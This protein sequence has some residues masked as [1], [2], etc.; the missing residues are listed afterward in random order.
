MRMFR[1]AITVLML[2]AP[3]HALAQDQ[4]TLAD[5]RQELTILYVEMQKLKRE[6]STTGGAT[7]NLAAA[8]VLDRVSAI[9]AEMQ[10]LTAQTERLDHR[11]QQIV[12][13]GT[14]RI[15]DLEFRL[16]ELEADCDISKLGESSTLGGDIPETPLPT[17][18]SDPETPQ[19]EL[20]VGEQADFEAA[21]TALSEQRYDDAAG[22]F[23]AFNMAYPGSPLAAEAN[24]HRGQALNG[25]GNTR[26]AARAFLASFTANA[27]GPVAAMALLELGTALGRLG[28]TS[29]ACVTL[30]EVSIRFPGAPEVARAEQEMVALG[31]S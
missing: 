4:Q 19:S 12:A 2:G 5:I 15:G 20:A 16:C 14:N 18:P 23:D 17:P 21:K 29:Q 3:M 31:C 25:V 26:E 8:G 1:L 6:F 13:D 7:S 27:N 30:A 9:E 28:Q 11:I 22:Q 10:R 24:L